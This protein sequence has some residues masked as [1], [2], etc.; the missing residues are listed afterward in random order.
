MP[1]F[2]KVKQKDT[3]K[4]YPRAVTT[5]HPYTTDE[6]VKQL[7]FMST[8]SPGDTYAV[9]MNLGEVLSKMMNS[10]RS[11]MLKGVG[12]FYYTCRAEGTGVD[13]PE[14]VGVQ[15]ITATQVRFIP[16]YTRTQNKKVNTRTLIDRD[17]FWQDVDDVLKNNN[18]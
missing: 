14:E 9:L 18:R 2:K 8:V 11:V 5:G 1:F 13:A 12:S 4:W 6:V 10:G 17:L 16:E 3:G 15:Q 7:S